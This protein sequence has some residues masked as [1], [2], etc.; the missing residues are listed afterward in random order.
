M[1]MTDLTW[2]PNSMLRS[3]SL[4]AGERDALV[5]IAE[6]GEDAVELPGGQALDKADGVLQEERD[7]DG[8]DE[9]HQ[10]RGVAQRA[11]GGALDDGGSQPGDDAGNQHGDDEPNICAPDGDAAEHPLA[12]KPD[13]QLDADESADGDDLAVGEVDELKHTVNHGIAQGD[14]GVDEADGDAIHQ[15]LR[16]VDQSIGKQAGAVIRPGKRIDRCAAQ[17]ES[18]DQDQGGEDSASPEDK[19]RNLPQRAKDLTQESCIKGSAH[20]GSRYD[21]R[22]SLDEEAGG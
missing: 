1:T 16:Q 2:M 14:G 19:Y 11:V 12:E 9:R 22:P 4:Q 21:P 3:A 13:Q 10:A 18:D 7:A 5:E 8:G 17:Q 15:H 6:G 20:V